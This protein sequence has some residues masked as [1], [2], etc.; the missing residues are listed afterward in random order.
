M[1]V[2]NN[3]YNVQMKTEDLKKYAKS[4]GL[5]VEEYGPCTSITFF[6]GKVLQLTTDWSYRIGFEFKKDVYYWWSILIMNVNSFDD[7]LWFEERYNR[8]NGVCQR[9]FHKGFV[10]EKEILNFV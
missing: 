3:K 10:A 5:K 9:T 1:N 2:N 8:V 6:E 4:K 7:D